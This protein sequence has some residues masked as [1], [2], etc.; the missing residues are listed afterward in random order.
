M[1]CTDDTL[2]LLLSDNGAAGEGGQLGSW[3]ELIPFNG[4]GDDEAR[5]IPAAGEL[6]APE[7]YPIYP[8]G[9]AQVGNT[10][11][12]WYKHHTFGGGVRAPLIVRWPG[13][14]V[15][16]GAFAAGFQHAID[17]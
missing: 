17:L 4:I 8:R 1:R 3:N 13:R 6:G 9:W 15:G 16:G 11:L 10:P 14:G 5:T 2:V 12:K 7:T